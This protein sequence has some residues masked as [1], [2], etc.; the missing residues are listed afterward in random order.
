MKAIGDIEGVI[1]AVIF[2]DTN[3][4]RRIVSARAASRKDRQEWLAS[5]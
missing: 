5:E 2:F 3:N 4:M 1:Y